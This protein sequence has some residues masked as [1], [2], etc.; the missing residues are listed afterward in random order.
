[1]A[2]DYYCPQC[3]KFVDID[4]EDHLHMLEWEL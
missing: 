3:R 2:A 4:M 1:M